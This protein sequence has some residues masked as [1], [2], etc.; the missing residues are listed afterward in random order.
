V[1]A[2]IVPL[3]RS[4]PLLDKLVMFGEAM[5]QLDEALVCSGKAQRPCFLGPL[6]DG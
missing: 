6:Y 5:Q 1:F 2:A 4:Q 3:L